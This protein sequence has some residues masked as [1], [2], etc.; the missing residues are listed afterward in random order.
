MQLIFHA[1]RA[2][3]IEMNIFY[4]SR[5]MNS[6]FPMILLVDTMKTWISIPLNDANMHL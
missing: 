2:L 6:N 3:P 1:K 5:G 4:P